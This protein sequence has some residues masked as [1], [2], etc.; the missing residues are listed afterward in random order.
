M[1]FSARLALGGEILS[2]TAHISPSFARIATGSRD[3]CIQVWDFDS[4]TCELKTVYSRRHGA[5][6]DIVPKAL[7][8]DN[9][10]DKD[11]FA[12]GLYDGGM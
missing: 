10:P 4:S 2:M 9:N 6:R 8:F 1:V 11:V 3:K 5:E 12:F 7:V